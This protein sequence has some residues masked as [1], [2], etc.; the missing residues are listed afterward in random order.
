MRGGGILQKLQPYDGQEGR[1]GAVVKSDLNSVNLG[2]VIPLLVVWAT[3]ILVG[4][5]LLILERRTRRMKTRRSYVTAL[6][7]LR[8]L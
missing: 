8:A 1:Q 2:D 4:A 6:S 5:S 7:D 3:S